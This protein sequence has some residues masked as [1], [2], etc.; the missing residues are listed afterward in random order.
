MLTFN[1]QI[2]I[3]FDKLVTAKI[4]SLSEDVVAGMLDDLGKYKSI[5]GQITGLRDA[6]D[7]L[8]EAVSNVERK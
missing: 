5:T 2:V 7:L 1:H 8:N 6:L 3:E 4:K